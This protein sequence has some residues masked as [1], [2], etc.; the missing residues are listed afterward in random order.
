[1]AALVCTAATAAAAIADGGPAPAVMQGWDGVVYGKIRY[2][3]VPAERGSAVQ[4]IRRDGGRVVRF[5][6]LRGSW[7]IPMVA[8]DGTAEGLSRD[9]RLLV[10]ADVN[11][12]H[13]LR[14]HS[15]FL[16][17]DTR[18][19]RVLGRIR[20]GGD[21]AFDAL[22]PDAQLLYLI[23]HV[24]AQDA[25]RYRVRAYDLRSRRLLRRI[26]SDKTSRETDMQGMPVSRLTSAG[27]GW[28]YTLYGGTPARP[29]IHALDLRRAQA[30][31][32][33]LPWRKQPRN[34]F[35]LR[36]RTD[37]DGHLVVRGPRGRALAVVDA[38]R[39]RLLRV[40]RDP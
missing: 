29:F 31:C 9:G 20:L 11:G 12:G 32:I 7:G 6:P 13:P 30:V 24:S 3:V 1:M 27:G 25:T 34:M 17:L 22:S 40:V 38:H 2:V 19:F 14:E 39:Q 5:R 36:L 4:A 21:F 33:D 10:L 35:Q 15:P 16:V 26:V 18:R 8:F 28:A 37:G 23:E